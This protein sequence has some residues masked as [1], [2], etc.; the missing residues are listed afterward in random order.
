M[1]RCFWL[2]VFLLLNLCVLAANDVAETREV[3][4]D[5][6]LRGR[7]V[8]T[9]IEVENTGDYAVMGAVSL[10][11]YDAAGKMLREQVV[12]PRWTTMIRPPHKRHTMKVEGSIHPK[13]A[14]IE[15]EKRVGGR[16]PSWKNVGDAKVTVGKIIIKPLAERPVNPH[17]FAEGKDGR[18]LKLEKGRVVY[19]PVYT[20]S[21]WGQGLKPLDEESFFSLEQAEISIDVRPDGGSGLILNAVNA[22]DNSPGIDFFGVEWNAEKQEL[23]AYLRGVDKKLFKASGKPA[24]ASGKWQT[25]KVEYGKTL[26]LSLDGKVVAKTALDGYQPAPVGDAQKGVHLFAVG[27][28]MISASRSETAKAAKG[29]SGVVDNLRITSGGVLRAAFDYENTIYGRSEVADGNVEGSILADEPLYPGSRRKGFDLW[30]GE[31]D[32]LNYKTLASDADMRAARRVA[33]VTRKAKPG[34]KFTLTLPDDALPVYTEIANRG[35]EPIYAPFLRHPDEVDPRSWE[36]MRETLKLEGL[37]EEEK[38]CRIFQWV[39][40]RLDYFI[41]HPAFPTPDSDQ[42]QAGCNHPLRNLNNSG[43]D[44]C[45]GVNRIVNNALALCGD[46]PTEVVNGYG[47][48][49]QQVFLDGMLRVFDMSGQ[50]CFRSLS[51]D[52]PA[53]LQELEREIGVFSRYRVNSS[54]FVRLFQHGP[55]GNQP[56]FSCRYFFTLRPG[57]SFRWYRN[58]DGAQNDVWYAKKTGYFKHPL[59]AEKPECCDI[60]DGYL[61]NRFQPEAANGFVIYEG[62]GQEKDYAVDFC[63][64]AVRGRYRAVDAAGKPLP[65]ELSKDGRRHWKPITTDAD[66]FARL[67]YEIRSLPRYFVRAKGG[68]PAKFSCVTE[69]MMNARVLTGLARPGKSDYLFTAGERVKGERVKGESPAAEITVAYKVPA[70][71]IEVEGAVNWGAIRGA[72]RMLLAYDPREGERVN[73]ERVKGEGVKLNFPDRGAPYYTNLVLKT[74]AGGSK[75][76]TVLVGRGAQLIHLGK[77]GKGLVFSKKGESVKVDFKPVGGRFMLFNLTRIPGGHRVDGPRERPL[78]Y[79][80]ETIAKHSYLRF[81]PCAGG[82]GPADYFKAPFGVNGGKAHRRWS[83]PVQ[84]GTKYP[85]QAPMVIEDG[86]VDHA[87]YEMRTDFADGLEFFAVLVIPEGDHAFQGETLKLFQGLNYEPLMAATDASVAD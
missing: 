27:G 82:N 65:L 80:D 68:A 1:R 72:E 3:P 53:S 61:M 81:K 75:V 2:S 57:E 71:E 30:P 32:T 37:G 21:V 58:N 40:G 7:R 10:R 55:R 24:F 34:E 6:A 62:R 26:V 84:K 33:S 47:H 4:F 36:T 23:S 52:S 63:Y 28:S 8:M 50:R 83:Y 44:M 16:K 41:C 60:R 46:L 66:G 67:D 73:G 54:H 70:G 14:K 76:L 5:A 69:L 17:F 59:T 48:E 51:D 31:F 29:F 77:D 35:S 56:D 38:A 19:F 11:Q 9:E 49:Y 13:T 74:S 18:G 43:A 12:D 20:R 42:P 39:I 22:R 45:G 15:M 79:I 85:S 86:A 25:V 64:T 87:C 78:C